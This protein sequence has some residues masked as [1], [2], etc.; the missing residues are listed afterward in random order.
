MTDV[1]LMVLIVLA[2]VFIVLY[3]LL[4][5]PKKEIRNIDLSEEDA[6]I[7]EEYVPFYKSLNEDARQRFRFRV[8]RFLSEVRISGVN[9]T[10]EHLDRLLVASSAIIPV[11]SF[12]WEYPNLNEVLIYPD[13]FNEKFEQE[14]GE[15]VILGMVGEGAMQNVMV[16]SQHELRQGFMN[17][18]GKTNTA[19]HEFVHLVDKT[20]GA[21]DGIPENIMKQKYIVPWLSLMHKKISEIRKGKSDINPY[22]STN[23]AEFFAVVSEYFFERPDLLKQ[24]HPELYQVMEQIFLPQSI[25]GSVS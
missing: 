23:E 2:T 24:K 7:L 14:G 16:L 18:T 8:S 10:V 19:I 6:L 21:T 11:F 15:R 9:T 22:G 1:I 13:Q 4:R 20:D 17:K 5:R 12:D 3:L 25:P